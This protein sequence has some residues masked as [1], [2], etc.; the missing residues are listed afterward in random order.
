MVK[1]DD[2]VIK[3][4]KWNDIQGQR[5]KQLFSFMVNLAASHSAKIKQHPK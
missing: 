3:G 1:S 5:R 4:Q 2:S